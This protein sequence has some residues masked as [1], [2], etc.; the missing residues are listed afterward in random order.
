[1]APSFIEEVGKKQQEQA[2]ND[3]PET[4]EKEQ[5]ASTLEE[6][7]KD[8]AQSRLFGSYLDRE[9]HWDVGQR[10]MAGESTDADLE[11]LRESRKE[12][13][14]INENIKTVEGRLDNA[15]I[16]AL[17]ESS[18]VL[19]ELA[20]IRG[21]ESMRASIMRNLSEVAIKD[22]ERF[23]ELHAVLADIA[24][25]KKVMEK[26]SEE[27]L[28]V[29]KE[30]GLSK[31]QYGALLVKLDKD[32]FA[33]EQ[34]LRN[35]T[36]LFESLKYLLPKVESLA[37]KASKLDK[38]DEIQR[39]LT[40]ANQLDGEL[41]KILREILM[42]NEVVRKDFIGGLGKDKKEP[43]TPELS[44]AEAV[45]EK[46]KPLSDDTVKDV[47]KRWAEYH[48]A[49]SSDKDYT[50][51]SG[52]SA[53]AKEYTKKKIKKGQSFWPFVAQLFLP[54]KIEKALKGN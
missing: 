25:A 27:M 49:H 39:S 8:S 48:G 4:Q 7:R 1:M 53:F 46:D 35:K 37:E 14:V 17:A 29:A 31:E 51:E 26:G 11:I 32:P 18:P 54:G 40:I 47:R 36:G 22:P 41:G 9:G 43:K 34:E 23:G 5:K 3:A 19:K 33:L 38:R 12:F 50:L 15:T 2:E 13:L 6:I 24:E 20:E 28:R 52:R 44:Y 16:I 45:A 21:P 30:H 10:M 42:E